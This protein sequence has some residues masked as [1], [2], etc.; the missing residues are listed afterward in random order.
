MRSANIVRRENFCSV[1]D[2]SNYRAE[3]PNK[4]TT[5]YNCPSLFSRGRIRS[6]TIIVTISFRIIQPNGQWLYRRKL[7]RFPFRFVPPNPRSQANT[8]L[9]KFPFGTCFAHIEIPFNRN[10]ERIPFTRNEERKTGG[11]S[12]FL[13]LFSSLTRLKMIE[14]LEAGADKNN[15][16]Y[17]IFISFFSL[18]Y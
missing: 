10:F 1:A 3:A 17:D 13:C 11:F 5:P 16:Q 8:E 2:P 4:L 18:K 12:D 9:A 14:V 15:K 7:P 6:P